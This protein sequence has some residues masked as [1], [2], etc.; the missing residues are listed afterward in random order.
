MLKPYFQERHTPRSELSGMACHSGLELAFG[1][2]SATARARRVLTSSS[3]FGRRRGRAVLATAPRERDDPLRRS[4]APDDR[5]QVHCC[6]P[7]G[8]AFSQLVQIIRSLPV[9]QVSALGCRRG[10]LVGHGLRI[11]LRAIGVMTMAA[12]PAAQRDRSR[13]GVRAADPGAFRR[14]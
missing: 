13:H 9:D 7:I 2:L 5:R 1:P 14:G 4:L 3:C 6:S 8:V 12:A 11:G 10:V